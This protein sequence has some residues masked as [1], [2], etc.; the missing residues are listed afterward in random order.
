M[1][2]KELVPAGAKYTKADFENLIGKRVKITAGDWTGKTQTYD[3]LVESVHVDDGDGK[4]D[5]VWLRTRKS[6]HSYRVVRLANIN[7]VWT[8]DAATKGGRRRRRSRQR[9]GGYLPTIDRL[10]ENILSALTDKQKAQAIPFFSKINE[11]IMTEGAW[12]DAQKAP[13]GG[14]RRRKTRRRRRSSTATRAPSEF[15]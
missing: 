15:L 2:W 3:E 5:G 12:I 6:K 13:G 14:R 10:D 11:I 9:R 4:G 8:W 1:S 7:K